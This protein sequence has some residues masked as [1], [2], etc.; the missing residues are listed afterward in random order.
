MTLPIKLWFGFSSSPAKKCVAH[1]IM[2]ICSENI[3]C[4]PIHVQPSHSQIIAK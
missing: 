1:Q 4:L 2:V 3:G